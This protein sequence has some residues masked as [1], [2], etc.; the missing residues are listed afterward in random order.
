[1]VTD[2]PLVTVAEFVERLKTAVPFDKAAAWDETGLQIGDPLATV[3]RVGVCHEVTEEVIELARADSV[4]LLVTYHPLLFRPTT[5]FVGGPGAG[6][7]AYRLAR[8]GCAVV[9]LHT[10]FDVAPGG[11]ADALGKAVGLEGMSGFGPAE[12][13][14]Q[15]MVVVFVP[16]AATE[17]VRRAMADAGAGSIG[18]YRAC[19]FESEGVG[20]W[21]A[22]AAAN[23]AMGAAGDSSHATEL[24]VEMVARRRSVPAI[25]SAIRHVHPYEEPAV[26]VTE[27][28]GYQGMIGRVGDIQPVVLSEAAATIERILGTPAARLVGDSSTTIRRVAVLPGSG[29]GFI[30]A[31]RATGADLLVTGDVTHHR[32]VEA[33]DAGLAVLDA[34]HAPTERPGMAAMAKLVAGL[35]LVVTD[36][37]TVSTDP[38]DRDPRRAGSLAERTVSEGG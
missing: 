21:D 34:G 14:D 28:E 9:S 19:S 26:Y 31:A 12:V 27:I 38:W 10:A 17:S 20:R 25:L 30:G 24:R 4:Q 22:G 1:M 36:L 15:V 13:A 3:H 11:T 5:R 6:G 8:D 2:R 7:R 29:G 18:H 16:E 32:A 35:G 23:P 37:T 33:R